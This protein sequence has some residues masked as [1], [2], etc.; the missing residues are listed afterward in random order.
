MSIQRPQAVEEPTRAKV[1]RRKVSK[2]SPKIVGGPRAPVFP[3]ELLSAS[4]I[5]VGGVCVQVTNVLP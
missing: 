3:R 2:L 4:V 5:H 1:R